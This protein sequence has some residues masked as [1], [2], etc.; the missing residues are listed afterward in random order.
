MDKL[1]LQH[2]VRLSNT[3]CLPGQWTSTLNVRNH[4]CCTCVSRVSQGD[5]QCK[6]GVGQKPFLSPVVHSKRN[7]RGDNRLSCC[8]H[9]PK[10]MGLWLLRWQHGE[11]QGEMS[12]MALYPTL[13]QLPESSLCSGCICWLDGL[14]SYQPR[15][16]SPPPAPLRSR[17]GAL[18]HTV[19]YLPGMLALS[20]LNGCLYQIP[21]P[22]TKFW[23]LHLSLSP[24]LFCLFVHLSLTH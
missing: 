4:W 10:R 24:F 1:K 18:Q 16:V 9:A 5:R 14:H 12:V 22:L 21:I 2:S 13:V 8:R 20:H 17:D 11:S 19:N 15:R 7:S 3:A 6:G 23:N